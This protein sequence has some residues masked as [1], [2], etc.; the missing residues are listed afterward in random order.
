MKTSSL[1]KRWT[2]LALSLVLVLGMLPLTAGAAFSPANYLR[3]VGYVGNKNTCKMTYDMA[4]SYANVLAKLPKDS[5]AILVAANDGKPVLATA[6][7]EEWYGDYY[8]AGDFTLWTWD[9]QQTKKFNYAKDMENDFDFGM[10]FGT[11]RGKTALMVWDGWAGNSVGDTGPYGTLIYAIQNGKFTLVKHSMTYR[12]YTEDGKYAMSYT[13][14]PLVKTSM[15]T[16]FGGNPMYKAKI[17]DMIQAGWV[18]DDRWEYSQY[19]PGM[20]YLEKEDGRY[21]SFDSIS[22]WVSWYESPREFK[23]WNWDQQIYE[24]TT[25]GEDVVGDWKSASSMAS[26]LRSYAQAAAAAQGSFLD[27]PTGNYAYDPV[28]WAVKEGITNGTSATTFSPDQTCTQGQILTFLWR[29]VGQPKATIANP[30]TN[31]TVTSGQYYYNAMLWAYEQGIVTSKSLNPN[32]GCQR[33]DVALYLWRLAGSPAAGGATF[34]DV[35]SSAPYA[36]AVAW[37][38][39]EGITNGTSATTFSPSATCTRGQIV[40]F[41]YR[42]MA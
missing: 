17:S 38:V 36:Q 6:L 21:L 32:A 10:E 27:V 16:D 28:V 8:Y 18:F 34:S 1:W 23:A 2:A 37:A 5:V 15:T 3:N 22:D 29:A 20:L 25:G 11:Y 39:Q 24:V 13:T 40:T 41:L 7:T 33:S 19:N 35:S 31:S 9:G 14:I 26:A 12:A 30:F 4:Q 42:D